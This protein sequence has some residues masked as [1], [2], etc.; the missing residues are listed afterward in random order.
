MIDKFPSK[1]TLRKY[2]LSQDEWHDIIVSQNYQCPICHREFDNKVKPVVD[3][4]HVR[5]YKKKS[6]AERNRLVRGILCIFCNWKIMTKG[7]TLEKARATVRY[8]EAYYDR[9][10]PT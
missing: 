3:H 4:I 6:S 5:N 10:L 1:A 8:L 7:M 9:E 2:G